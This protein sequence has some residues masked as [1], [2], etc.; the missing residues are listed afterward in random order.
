MFDR[1]F[2]IGVGIFLAVCFGIAEFGQIREKGDTKNF[3]ITHNR[4]VM[5][6]IK[7][8][9]WNITTKEDGIHDDDF[10]KLWNSGT[11]EVIPIKEE[12]Y[13]CYANESDMFM[14]D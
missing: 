12:K 7:E 11:Y 1:I 10:F 3:L 9:D 13:Y 2:I 14:E 8:S 6:G 4:K 5:L